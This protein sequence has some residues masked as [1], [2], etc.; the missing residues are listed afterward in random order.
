[1]AQ[2]IN[3]IVDSEQNLIKVFNKLNVVTTKKLGNVQTI[4]GIDFE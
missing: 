4:T 1:M 2:P 3:T